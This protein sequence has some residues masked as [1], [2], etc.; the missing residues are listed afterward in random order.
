[1]TAV[2]WAAMT[3]I[4]AVA[5]LAL[6]LVLVVARRLRDLTAQLAKLDQPFLPD[7]PPL[8]PV[9][10]F[11]ATTTAGLRLTSADLAGPDQLLLFLYGSCESCH[12]NLP[13][14]VA[15]L[16]DAEVR[17]VAVV[18]GRPDLRAA[19]TAGLA[20]VA[21][22]IEEYDMSGLANLFRVTGFP[23]YL[24]IETGEIVAVGHGLAEVRQRAGV[25]A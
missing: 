21:H 10:D 9:P 1:M 25:A 22:V 4:S 18:V 23:S 16:A 19:L 7:L 14:T 2:A 20:P 11:T 8:G 3:L 12:D 15:A 17:P 5:V 24:R 6:A 13:Q